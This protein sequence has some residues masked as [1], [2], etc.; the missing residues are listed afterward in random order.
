[1]KFRSFVLAIAV[2][3]LLLPSPAFAQDDAAQD[4]D[5]RSRIAALV[6]RFVSGDDS[7]EISPETT[8]EQLIEEAPAFEIA[9][10]TVT[11]LVAGITV[12][13]AI[14]LIVRGY[15]TPTKR[16]PFRSKL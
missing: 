12:I 8:D 1:M 15:Q 16:D 11:G 2:C 3:L 14:G 9:P 7:A 6:E 13:F 4:L 10:E 5:I